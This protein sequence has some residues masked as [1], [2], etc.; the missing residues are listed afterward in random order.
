MKKYEVEVADRVA[1]TIDFHAESLGITPAEAIRYTLG[2]WARSVNPPPPR[3]QAIQV[4]ASQL[5]GRPSP[6]P[7]MPPELETMH[8]LSL[9]SMKKAVKSGEVK[10][11]HCTLP[12]TWEAI[13]K[14]ECQS[15][16]GKQ[17]LEEV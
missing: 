3:I 16:G 4:D 15:C 9:W 7:E 1:E 6:P 14:N 17:P 2:T 12:L 8:R 11:R 5:F 10:C 13:E